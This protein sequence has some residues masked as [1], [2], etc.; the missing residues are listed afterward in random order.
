[1][2]RKKSKPYISTKILKRPL[3]ELVHIQVR[4]VR[5]AKKGREKNAKHA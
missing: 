1:M 2:Q 3:R 4:M 5:A